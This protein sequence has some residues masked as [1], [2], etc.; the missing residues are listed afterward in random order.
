MS[1]Y[2]FCSRKLQ[3]GEPGSPSTRCHGYFL[4]LLKE[5]ANRQTWKPVYPMSWQSL[6]FARGNCANRRT[7]KPIYP[8]AWLFFYFGSR[9]LQIGEPGSPS[10][11]RHG[12][13]LFLREE[14][15]Q[16]GEPG[17]PSTRRHGNLLFL[18][19]E[20]VQIGGREV[21]FLA[22]TRIFVIV[23]VPILFFIFMVNFCLHWKKLNELNKKWHID[24]SPV[25]SFHKIKCKELAHKIQNSSRK[26]TDFKNCECQ[27]MPHPTYFPLI[28]P[29]STLSHGP[30]SFVFVCHSAFT[31]GINC[32]R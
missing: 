32:F 5:T 4:F 14:T 20:T 6:I 31:D 23:A 27:R 16:I 19:E 17:S 22:E 15:V 3:I 8:I 12:N 18:L 24:I 30:E 29:L 10:T 26:T 11:R 13:L 7:W 9:K 21:S 1:I 28:E 25:P 2:Y